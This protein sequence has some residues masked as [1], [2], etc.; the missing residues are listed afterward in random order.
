MIDMSMFLH[1][2]STVIAIAINVGLGK[3]WL[4]HPGSQASA[5]LPIPGLGLGL[6]ASCLAPSLQFGHALAAQETFGVMSSVQHPAVHGCRL[7]SQEVRS[8]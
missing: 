7:D 4:L 8:K 3:S 5:V 1:M 2:L 6:L